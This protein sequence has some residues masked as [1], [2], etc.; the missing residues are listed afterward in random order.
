MKKI[1][2]EFRDQRL[3]VVSRELFGRIKKLPVSRHLYVT[4]IGHFPLAGGHSVYRKQGAEEYVMIFCAS[5]KGCV[6]TH[7]ARREMTAG[8]LIL[9][10]PG[11][12]HR[13]EADRVLPWNIYWF[14]YTG[15]QTNEYADLLGIDETIPVRQIGD[16]DSLIRQFESLYAA[17]ISAF[18]DSALI[19]SSIEL[20][21]TLCL[22][23]S[24]R[25]SRHKNSLKSE[26]RILSSVE[27][28][29]RQYH[30]PHTLEELA[31]NVGLS[32]P[33]YVALFR[34]HT[35][36]TP[37]R[38][39]TGIRLRRACELL[40]SSDKRIAEIARAVGYD[41]AFYFSRAFRKITG[42]SPTDYRTLH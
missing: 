37:I 30:T 38:F 22:I 25:T 29:T 28:L 8:Q 5:G 2:G 40:I 41:D 12:S 15:D 19:L 17:W 34:Q 11:V 18:S 35:G 26:R 36:T 21:K 33:H 7:G 3:F 4:D 1:R 10:P 32:V 39:L 9:I 14:H 27:Y 31:K 23:N 42:H 6:R 24:L 20:A 13:Y 16:T